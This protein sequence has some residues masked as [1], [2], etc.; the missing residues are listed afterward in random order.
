MPTNGYQL[1]VMVGGKGSTIGTWSTD[2][3]GVFVANE[4]QH[5]AVTYND[6]VAKVYRNGNAVTFN[7][8]GTTYTLPDGSMDGAT[9]FKFRN[10]GKYYAVGS[11]WNGNISDM[12][13]YNTDLDDT[14]IT[15][16]YNSGKPIDL[17]CDAG[18]YNNANNM[19]GYWKMG[20]GYLDEL[21][22]AT[23][24]GGILDQVVPILGDEIITNGNF[25]EGADGLD[26]WSNYGLEEGDSVTVNSDN[27]LV[28]VGNDKNDYAYQGN[29]IP[30]SDNGIYRLEIDIDSSSSGVYSHSFNGSLYP[31]EEGALPSGKNV[32]YFQ[33]TNAGIAQLRLS[34]GI[35]GGTETM[36]TFVINS[37][38]LK[39][40]NGNP[41]ICK[42]M[43]ASAQS[44]S[45][46][47]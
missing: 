42:N 37:V 8:G 39:K 10:I 35:T 12:A 15:A 23:N 18:N 40:V 9:E 7:T 21:P 20:D 31:N 13:I 27:Q 26:G 29:L 16:I 44:I 3:D 14:N 43:N 32:F 5:L 34:G 17:T 47:E 4:W 2:S 30:G 19:V 41:G 24:V 46:P 45:V 11:N 28:I 6:G 36:N 1:G 33:W 25:T 22:S 38:S